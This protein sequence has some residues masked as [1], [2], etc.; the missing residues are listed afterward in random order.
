MHFSS[1][2]WNYYIC[3]KFRK[4]PATTLKVSRGHAFW[5]KFLLTHANM[6]VPWPRRQQLE[7]YWIRPLHTHSNTD[8]T[9]RFCGPSDNGSPMSSYRNVTLIL[10]THKSIPLPK[11][12]CDWQV[13]ESPLYLCTIHS[14]LHESCIYGMFTYVF[15]HTY[16]G[17]SKNK[18]ERLLFEC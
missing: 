1:L 16:V 6:H 18:Y 3:I 2:W 5:H 9:E 17:W 15:I 11:S 13:V 12:V 7:K 14:N 4:N 10:P 8:L